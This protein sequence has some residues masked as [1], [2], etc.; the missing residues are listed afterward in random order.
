VNEGS[1]D[2][3]RCASLRVAARLM[4]KWKCTLKHS[5]RG[6]RAWTLRYK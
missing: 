2:V 3:R 1:G 4:N 6:R 5:E